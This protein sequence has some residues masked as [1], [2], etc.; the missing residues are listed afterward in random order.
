M[1]GVLFFSKY[2]DIWPQSRHTLAVM[3]MKAIGRSA[4]HQQKKM[5]LGPRGGIVGT[6]LQHVAKT[7]NSKLFSA[8]N[9][10]NASY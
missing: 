8:T 5:K 7:N 1:I 9:S 4:G 2:T 3:V 10:S 6:I